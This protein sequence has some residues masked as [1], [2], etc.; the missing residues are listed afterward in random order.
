MGDVT[1]QLVKFLLFGFDLFNQIIN[2]TL[3]VVEFEKLL[4]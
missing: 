3:I 4:L 1:N 2:L